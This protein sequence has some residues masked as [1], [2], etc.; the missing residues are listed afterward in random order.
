MLLGH[1][2]LGPP[3]SREGAPTYP[4]CHLGYTAV[5]QF[6]SMSPPS[7]WVLR[8]PDAPAFS[9]QSPWVLRQGQDTT[10][11]QV[12]SCVVPALSSP[13]SRGCKTG[14]VKGHSQTPH[15]GLQSLRGAGLSGQGCLR[16]GRAGTCSDGGQKGTRPCTPGGSPKLPGKRSRQLTARH[17]NIY[18]LGVGGRLHSM[19]STCRG[20]SHPDLLPAAIFRVVRN[21]A[22]GTPN[23]VRTAWSYSENAGSRRGC[24]ALRPQDTSDPSVPAAE[25]CHPPRAEP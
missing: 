4:H 23:T 8:I 16:A 12:G 15:R 2:S 20:C 7:S 9:R 19:G 10:S 24:R 3:S 18:T 11:P 1:L 5:N 25:C 6:P 13:L 21:H 17:N 22:T 14:L